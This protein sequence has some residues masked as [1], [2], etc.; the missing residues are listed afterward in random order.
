MKTQYF[1][2][3]IRRVN[4]AVALV[5]IMSVFAGCKK[6]EAP[7]QIM[8]PAPVVLAKAEQKDTFRF[9]AS[10]ATTSAYKSATIVPQV[11]G[12][13]VSIHF[14][15]GDYVKEGDILAVVDKRPYEA[16]VL[17]AE[18]QLMQAQASLKIN[19][20]AVERNKKLAEQ[21]YVDKQTFDTLLARVDADKG[22]VKAAQAALELAKINLDW[23]TVKAPIGGKVGLYNINVGNVVGAGVSPI[24]TIEQLDRLYVDFVVPTHRLFQVKDLMKA[25]G[26]KL[27][28]EVSFL[29]S[30]FADKVK[31]ATVSILENQSRY[32]TS[33]TVL[34]GELDNTDGLFAA[35]QSVRVHLFTEEVKGGIFVPDAAIQNDVVG[36]FIY[37]AD[38][39]E[40]M[41]FTTRKV[42]IRKIQQFP[43]GAQLVEGAKDATGKQHTI[44]GGDMVVVIGQLRV[45]DG[46]FAYAAIPQGAPIGANGMPITNPE[47]V[48]KFMQAAIQLK[49]KH[50]MQAAAAMQPAV[51]DSAKAESKPADKQ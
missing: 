38:K 19:E 50:E 49:V 39:L 22:A 51:K 16:N 17:A 43:N 32:E 2:K 3:S 15:Q 18:A 27:D 28:I 7:K 47:E 42:Y 9:I 46:A 48:G 10:P 23:C 12:Q 36:T 4:L 24:T 29:E 6:H 26:G 34:R 5:A 30:G 8:P 45:A 11:S 33:T 31:K 13:I 41:L 35:P 44:N 1:K 20:L 37:V 21:N 25:R 14:K 40:D